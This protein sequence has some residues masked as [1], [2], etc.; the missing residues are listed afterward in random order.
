MHLFNSCAQS[1]HDGM[2]LKNFLP[3]QIAPLS[4]VESKKVNASVFS[5]A[6]EN[7]LFSKRSEFLES[8]KMHF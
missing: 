1:R 6:A 8:Q 7:E 2:I 3:V 5:I 4:V